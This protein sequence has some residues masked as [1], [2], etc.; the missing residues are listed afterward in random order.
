[1][2]YLCIYVKSQLWSVL[3]KSP[4]VTSLNLFLVKY[5]VLFLFFGVPFSMKN[6]ISNIV[7]LSFDIIF[8]T[9]K[10]LSYSTTLIFFFFILPC[11]ITLLL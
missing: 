4:S 7:K 11:N 10:K 6:N 2:L 5:S 8:I 1:M 9:S 3:S